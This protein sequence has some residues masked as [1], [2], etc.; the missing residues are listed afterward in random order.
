MNGSKNSAGRNFYKA[1]SAELTV[2]GDCARWTLRWN[3]GEFV[4]GIEDTKAEAV[5]ALARYGF[6]HD[7]NPVVSVQDEVIKLAA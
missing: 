7:N 4:Y 6:S 2:F 3:D 5:A 1:D